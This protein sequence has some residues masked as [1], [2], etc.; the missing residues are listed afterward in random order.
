MIA[1]VTS[2]PHRVRRAKN[3]AFCPAVVWAVVTA[4]NPVSKCKRRVIGA[5]V[6][7]KN[8]PHARNLDDLPKAFRTEIEHFF[9]SYN[10]LEG[11]KFRVL[12]WR[13]PAAAKRLIA[14]GAQAY[15]DRN[16]RV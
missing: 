16:R 7:E 8:P 13:G 12:A 10:E 4:I 15:R 5:L 2:Q 11:R 9:V 1:G 6:T 3:S 14:Q